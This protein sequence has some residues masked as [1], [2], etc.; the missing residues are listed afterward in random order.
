MGGACGHSGPSEIQALCTKLE[1]RPLG[2]PHGKPSTFS[3]GLVS[4]RTCCLKCT[5][6]HF[7]YLRS[8]LMKV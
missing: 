3:C 8:V 6:F 1:G 5:P 4:D 2:Q 7:L